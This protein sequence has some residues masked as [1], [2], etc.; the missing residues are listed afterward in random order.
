MSFFFFGLIDEIS[1]QLVCSLLEPVKPCQSV[2]PAPT[3]PTLIPVIVTQHIAACRFPSDFCSA[4]S[5]LSH[6]PVLLFLRDPYLLSPAHGEHSLSSCS[7][8]V[9]SRHELKLKN[10]FLFHQQINL[11]SYLLVSRRFFQ[12]CDRGRDA[13]SFLPAP[14]AEVELQK[15]KCKN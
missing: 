11:F 1:V 13:R 2:S 4:F 7:A 5:K 15:K 9:C 6:Q 10:L 12:R 14:P 8:P 3:P